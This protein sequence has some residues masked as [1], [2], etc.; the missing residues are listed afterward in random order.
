MKVSNAICK[1]FGTGNSISLLTLYNTITKQ[2][3]RSTCV[4]PD[5]VGICTLTTNRTRRFHE[6]W[7][8]KMLLDVLKIPCFLCSILNSEILVFSKAAVISWNVN[9]TLLRACALHCVCDVIIACISP[10]TF[11]AL[12]TAITFLLLQLRNAVGSTFISYSCRV[13][14][15]VELRNI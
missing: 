14:R 12:A 2:S 8:T 6:L 7:D 15:F 5:T 9:S 3:H 1:C 10:G 11:P 13:W 4:I